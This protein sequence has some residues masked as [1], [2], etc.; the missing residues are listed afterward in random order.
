MAKRAGGPLA[1]ATQFVGLDV[2]GFPRSACLMIL[3]VLGAAGC[4]DGARVGAAR[5]IVAH[6]FLSDLS[7]VYWQFLI[8]L[9]MVVAVLFARA[10]DPRR[11][12]TAVL[13]A[14]GS[15]RAAEPTSPLTPP[16]LDRSRMRAI[17]KRSSS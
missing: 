13:A 17:P 6:H 9:R 8:G 3:L 10:G 2:F 15:A 4:L 5:F 14:A 16:A 7:P 12:R 11:A 1:Q